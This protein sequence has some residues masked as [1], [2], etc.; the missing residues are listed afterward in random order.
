[1]LLTRHTVTWYMRKDTV[2]YS[3]N[4]GAKYATEAIMPKSASLTQNRNTMHLETKVSDSTYS[5]V[6]PIEK[7]DAKI[8]GAKNDVA[9]D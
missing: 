8:R 7:C 1:M 9:K 6:G 2:Y 4:Q 5:T 3:E